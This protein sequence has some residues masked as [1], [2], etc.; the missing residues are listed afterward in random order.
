MPTA[1]FEQ[2]ELIA[3]PT[4]IAS[5]SPNRDRAESSTSVV[6]V[7]VAPGMIKVERG[8]RGHWT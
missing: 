1:D 3:E 2:V 8:W 5:L 7:P 6:T 4:L